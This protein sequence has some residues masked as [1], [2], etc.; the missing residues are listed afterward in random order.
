M[1]PYILNSMLKRLKGLFLTDTGQDTSI[2]LAGTSINVLAGGLFFIFV[3][4]F[5]G[6]ADYG[7]FSVVISTCLMV[8]A[9]ANFGLD[10]GILRFAAKNNSVLGFAFKIYLALGALTAVFGFLLA[11]IIASLLGYPQMTGLLRIGFTGI[12]FLLLTNFFVAALQSR[13]EFAKASIVSISSNLSRLLILGTAYYFFT[14]NLFF[15]TVLFFF[16][17]IM[18][19]VIGIIYQPLNLS[20][21]TTVKKEFFKYNFW[22]A[23]AL[24]ISAIPFDN[25]LLL[26]LSSSTAVGLYAMPYKLLTFS[27]QFGGNFTRVLASRYS[28]FD[29]RQKAVEF[30]KKSIVFPGTFILGLIFLIIVSPLFT[31]L[32]GD[33]YQGSLPVMQ[34][35][36]VGFIF[37]FASTIPSSLILYYFGRSDI[38]FYITVVRYISFIILLI[39]LVPSNQAEGGAIAFTL[40]ELLAFALMSV[41]V[42]YK[43]KKNEH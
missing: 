15:L 12:I 17:T 28:T 21:T 42:T 23:A 18:S 10:T 25:Y 39:V 3:P 8:A 27:H 33:Q 31:Q 34:I 20:G 29:T 9:I 22:I 35:L 14:V 40:S 43:F 37:F 4:W 16:V 38:S 6:P 1:A 41:F 36:S 13:G 7:L 26:L 2:V 24:I 32:F 30:T 5:L 19:V 11:P